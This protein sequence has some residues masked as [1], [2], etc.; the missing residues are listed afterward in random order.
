MESPEAGLVVLD[1]C[2]EEF[3]VVRIKYLHL[4][5]E[6]LNHSRLSYIQ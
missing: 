3:A 6:G 5:D 2:V 4:G 1:L